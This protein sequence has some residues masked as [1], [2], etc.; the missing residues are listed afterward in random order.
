MVFNPK[1]QSMHFKNDKKKC[2]VQRIRYANS[3]KHAKQQ[4]WKKILVFI[5]HQ[6]HEIEKKKKKKLF[7]LLIEKYSL[8]DLSSLWLMLADEALEQQLW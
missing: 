1:F 5:Q 3:L 8:H 6:G 7:F 2:A 4:I